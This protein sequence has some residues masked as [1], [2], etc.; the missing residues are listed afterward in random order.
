[1]NIWLGTGRETNKMA[2]ATMN[3]L[4]KIES[5]YVRAATPVIITEIRVSFGN[6]LVTCLKWGF[7]ALIAGFII[8]ICGIPLWII[9]GGLL[10]AI[11]S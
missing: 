10:A 3:E 7:A 2:A 9:L 8:G 11:S 1:M 6:A 4:P 5:G